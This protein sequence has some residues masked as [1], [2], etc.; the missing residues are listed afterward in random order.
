M[1]R[2]VVVDL[3]TTAEQPGGMQQERDVQR[4]AAESRGAASL[5]VLLKVSTRFL[6]GRPLLGTGVQA[7]GFDSEG[8]AAAGHGRLEK[9]SSRTSWG[10]PGGGREVA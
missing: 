5:L 2:S 7:A 9:R 8:R 4:E 3:R 1:E 10:A 6:L